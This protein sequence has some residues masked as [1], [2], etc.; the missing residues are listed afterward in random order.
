MKEWEK[1]PL[2]KVLDK[3]K[4]MMKLERKRRYTPDELYTH[5]MDYFK[6]CDE[7]VVGTDKNGNPMTKP[8][9]RSWLCLYLK[10]HGD[11]ISVNAKRE[12]YEDVINYIR[13]T[14]ANDIEEKMLTGQYNASGAI[15]AMKNVAGWTDRVQMDS[16]V[17]N[18]IT[19]TFKQ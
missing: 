18:K 14:T 4:E 1:A 5:S 2:P 16:V 9:T 19:I 7:T 15:F 6:Q 13:Q 10:V 8:K 17:D 3:P 11:F 12:Q